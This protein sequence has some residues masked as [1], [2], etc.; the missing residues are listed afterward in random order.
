MSLGYWLLGQGM[1]IMTAVKVHNIREDLAVGQ[2]L[3]NQNCAIE[4]MQHSIFDWYCNTDKKLCYK[5]TR[6]AVRGLEKLN[7]F[8]LACNN[9]TANLTLPGR[10]SEN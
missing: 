6:N 2:G 4:S 1:W 8:I 10:G 5:L 7:I 3:T 9:I